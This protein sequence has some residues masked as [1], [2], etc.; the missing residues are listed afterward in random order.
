MEILGFK[1]LLLALFEDEHTVFAGISVVGG[2][3]VI[4]MMGY[5]CQRQCQKPHLLRHSAAPVPLKMQR[6][7]PSLTDHCGNESGNIILQK[8]FRKIPQIRAIL[9]L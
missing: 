4:V 1:D 9:R 3:L 8:A 5:F 7:D 6:H 2:T